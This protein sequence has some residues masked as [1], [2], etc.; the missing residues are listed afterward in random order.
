MPDPV[1]L[2][3]FFIAA[4]ALN[5]TP[6]ADMTYVIARAAAQGRAAGIAASFGIAGGSLVHT[7]LAAF[8]VSA[9]LAHSE[10]AFVAV[11]SAGV[12]YLLYLAWKALKAG[13]ARLSGCSAPAPAGLWR[14]FAEG[15][16]TNVLNP[17]VALFILAFLPQFVDPRA[18]PVWL[19]I[20]V[21]GTLFNISGTAV[22]CAVAISAATA[23]KLLKGSAMVGLWLNR[24]TALVFVGLALRL[25][26]AER[27]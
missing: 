10:A 13:K 6:G 27:R 9:L 22:N 7:A 25:A 11:K 14:V 20:L 8:G 16:L 18:G 4:L 12:A 19:Q 24:L 3:P 2:V 1:A 23:A 5:L 21:L 26:L 17:K 15:A